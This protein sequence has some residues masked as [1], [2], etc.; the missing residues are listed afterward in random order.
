MSNMQLMGFEYEI[1][2]ITDYL[3]NMT[4]QGRTDLGKRFWLMGYLRHFF[5]FFTC[6]NLILILD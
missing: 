4:G 2:V 6:L 5:Y 1:C 3:E